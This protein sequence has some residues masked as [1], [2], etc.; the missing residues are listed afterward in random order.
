MTFKVVQGHR[1]PRGLIEDNGD[2]DAMN[3]M[4]F[5]YTCKQ[6]SRSFI[7]AYHTNRFLICDFL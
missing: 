3:D 7:S 1:T 6:R 2:C 5:N 4:T